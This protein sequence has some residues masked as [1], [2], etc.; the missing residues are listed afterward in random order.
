MKDTNFACKCL[1]IKK[2]KNGHNRISERMIFMEVNKNNKKVEEE[3]F[4]NCIY[5]EKGTTI[6]SVIEDAFKLFY[7][8]KK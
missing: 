5:D 3:F 6:T 7:E 1:S 4:L 2:I 8:F